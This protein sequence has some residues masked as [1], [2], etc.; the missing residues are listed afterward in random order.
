MRIRKKNK[1]AEKIRC[2]DCRWFI[3]LGGRMKNA[4]NSGCCRY[5]E[6]SGQ[7]PFPGNCAGYESKGHCPH[8]EAKKENKEE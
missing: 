3:P 2:S 6:Y 1:A 7:I 5:W 4:N 8:F